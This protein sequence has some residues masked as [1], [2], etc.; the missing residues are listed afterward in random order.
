MSG[1]GIVLEN[2]TAPFAYPCVCD[3]KLGTRL[4]DDQADPGK[5][6]RMIAQANETTSGSTGLRICGLQILDGKNT[7]VKLDRRFG[8]SLGADNLRDGFV[9]FFSDAAGSMVRSGVIES[10]ICKLDALLHA[11]RQIEP[12][13]LAMYSRFAECAIF[14]RL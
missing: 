9:R 5:K 3:V 6:A 1:D 11:L 2:L 8:R 14:T 12:G 13:S 7:Q 10:T 4:Y